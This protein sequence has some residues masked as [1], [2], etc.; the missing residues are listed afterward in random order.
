M[1]YVEGTGPVDG[2]P[3]RHVVLRLDHEPADGVQVTEFL[4][5]EEDET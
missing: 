3:D 4:L 5:Q 2:E 1:K